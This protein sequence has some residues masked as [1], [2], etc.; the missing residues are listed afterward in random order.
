MRTYKQ[1][2]E[3]LHTM[4]PEEISRQVSVPAQARPYQGR[5]AG[6]VTRALA[7]GLDITLIFVTVILLEVAFA[8][9]RF[10]V[11]GT[12]WQ[13]DWVNTAFHLAGAYILFVLYMTIAWRTTGRSF[14][15]QIMGLRV[16]NNNGLLLRSVPA[17]LRALFVGAFPIGLVWVVF[18]SGNRSV[19]DVFLGTSVIYD[20]EF[21]MLKVEH[22]PKK[23]KQEKQKVKS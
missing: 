20:W 5:R 21:R 9:V 2:R 15:A 14:G 8:I 13:F 17:F 11:S 16:V 4:T 18:S 10:L 7:G 1:Y 6:F 22:E 12:D 23:A 19:Q 3:L